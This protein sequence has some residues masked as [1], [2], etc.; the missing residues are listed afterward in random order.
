E[1]TTQRVCFERSTDFFVLNRRDKIGDG[2]AL[3]MPQQMNSVRDGI[4][5]CRSDTQAA[6]SA[7][8]FDPARCPGHVAVFSKF[9]KWVE[10]ERRF[11]APQIVKLPAARLGQYIKRVPFVESEH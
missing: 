1:W 9:G 2:A 7:E 3:C 5:L 4:L 11:L 10:R 6:E 8:F